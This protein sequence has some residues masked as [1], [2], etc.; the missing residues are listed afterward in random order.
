MFDVQINAGINLR[1]ICIERELS[2]RDFVV[3]TFLGCY[4]LHYCTVNKLHLLYKE[5]KFEKYRCILG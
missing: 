3:M 4:A 2:M 5:E 1:E